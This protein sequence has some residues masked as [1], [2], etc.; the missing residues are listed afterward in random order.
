[1]YGHH[2]VESIGPSRIR[3]KTTMTVTG[4]LGFLWRKLV[5]QGIVDDLPKDTANIIAIAKKKS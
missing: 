3:L 2:E 1:M 5:A 4:P